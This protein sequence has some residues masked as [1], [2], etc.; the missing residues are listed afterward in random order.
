MDGWGCHQLL[1]LYPAGE[2]R[3]IAVTVV[4]TSVNTVGTSVNTVSIQINTVDTSV[5]IVGIP[6]NIVGT[7]VNTVS[8]RRV[9]QPRLYARAR[10]SVFPLILKQAG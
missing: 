3:S 2:H 1:V 8:S 4:G 5:N 10:R 7:S 6:V 9:Y